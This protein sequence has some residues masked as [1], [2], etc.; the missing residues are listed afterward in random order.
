MSVETLL[1]PA[2]KFNDVKAGKEK[3]FS[4]C[5]AE[6]IIKCTHQNA[7]IVVLILRVTVA[8]DRTKQTIT[9]CLY[10]HHLND[11]SIHIK[12]RVQTFLA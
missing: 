4:T 7:E 11:T 8:R 3:P 1:S 5:R 2:I 6:H 10:M 9:L 12:C